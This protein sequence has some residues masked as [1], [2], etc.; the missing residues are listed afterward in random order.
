MNKDTARLNR[1]SDEALEQV[2]GGAAGG[3]SGTGQT[4][5]HICPNK[6]CPSKKDNY[7]SMF[8]MYSGG[9]AYC[10]NCHQEIEK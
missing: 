4:F 10:V 2:S 6:N 1:I 7:K 8:K 9:R 3:N 5:P